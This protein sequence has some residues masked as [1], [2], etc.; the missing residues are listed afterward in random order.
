MSSSN[1]FSLLTP[2]QRVSRQVSI[3]LSHEGTKFQVLEE[4]KKE[5]K[6]AHR[7]IRPLAN[8]LLGF[9]SYHAW[10]C[11]T[12]GMKR[13]NTKECK[14]RPHHDTHIVQW[15]AQG[16]LHTNTLPTPC[17]KTSDKAPCWSKP[18]RELSMNYIEIYNLFPSHKT[19]KLI[20]CSG[21]VAP[22]CIVFVRQALFQCMR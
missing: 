13:Y 9:L 16:G 20:L 8:L 6:N 15:P 5:K 21:W 22:L 18:N 7:Q 10:G 19:Q 3:L 17:N 2:P 12:S 1:R 11:F 14:V 4:K